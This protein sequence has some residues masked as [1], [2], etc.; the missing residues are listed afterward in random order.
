MATIFELA[1]APASV[2]VDR[3]RSGIPT[4]AFR[5]LAD[6]LGVSQNELAA[7][8]RV[9][10]RTLTRLTSEQK[11]LPPEIA[12]KV[13]RAAR[14]MIKARTLFS[15]DASVITW[16]NT[17]APALRGAKPIDLLD[18]DVGAAEVEGLI[19]GLAYGNFQ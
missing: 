5:M 15:D 8:L 16:L 3:I 6:R 2:A 17:D 19:L 18:T 7:K 9:A 13:L 10:T 11:P 14:V 4:S 12:Q 1:E